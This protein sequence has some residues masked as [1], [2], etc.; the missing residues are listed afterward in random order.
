[1]TEATQTVNVT[2]VE[3]EK[4][5]GVIRRGASA[6]G[7]CC[8]ALKRIFIALGARLA[9]RN[10]VGIPRKLASGF[11]SVLGWLFFVMSV[12]TLAAGEGLYALSTKIGKSATDEEKECVDSSVGSPAPSVAG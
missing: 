5:P 10:G 7:R 9:G 8:S 6:L 12:P 3:T 1:M 11:L 4:K 2:P